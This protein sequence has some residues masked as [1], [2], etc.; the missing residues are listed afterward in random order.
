MNKILFFTILLSITLYVNG[1]MGCSN[2]SDCPSA[3][4]KC[5]KVLLGT[6][7]DAQ[8]KNKYY[9]ICLSKLIADNAGLIIV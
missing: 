2:D 1:L 5:T 3:T 6:T 7:K 9:T 4:Q 8:K